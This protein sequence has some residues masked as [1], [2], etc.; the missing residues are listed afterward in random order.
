[1]TWVRKGVYISYTYIWLSRFKLSLILWLLFTSSLSSQSFAAAIY[2][3]DNRRVE[4]DGDYGDGYFSYMRTPDAPFADFDTNGQTSSLTSTGFSAIG[5]GDAYS[6]Y[7]W[8]A[9]WS[10][11]DVSFNLTTEST[12]SLTGWLNGYD[13]YYG[14][15]DA[16]VA[17]YSGTSILASNILYTESV[18]AYNGFDQS[19]VSFDSILAT[20]DYRIIIKADPYFQIASSS[21]NVQATFTPTTVPIPTAVWLFGSGLI[22]LIG[23]ARRKKA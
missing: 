14:S 19:L 22:G 8:S 18:A 7:G 13:E 23:V 15:G 5:N 12:I 6:D 17:L 9:G 3:D 20:G 16:S 2:L 10:F 1:M 4:V 21:F 11:F